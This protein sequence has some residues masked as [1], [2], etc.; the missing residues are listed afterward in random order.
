MTATTGPDA[1]PGPA[2]DSLL[3][4]PRLVAG[5]R[6]RRRL[7][8]SVA[9]VGMLAGALIGLFP[10]HTAVARVLIVHETELGDGGSLMET[11]VALFETNRIAAA[12]AERLGI[13]E[14]P[15]VFR[16]SFAGEGLTDNIMEITV[17]AGSDAEA[18][19]RAGA[20]AEVFLADHVRRTE[21]VASAESRALL[22]RREQAERDLDAVNDQIAELTERPAADPAAAGVQLDAL[23]GQR[24]ELADQIQEFGQ[25]AGDAGFGAPRVAA[26]TRIVDPPRVTTSGRLTSVV[27]NAAVGSVLGLGIG[28]ALAAVATIVRDRPVLRRDIADHLGASVIVQVDR[29]RRR[30][31]RFGRRSPDGAEH[32]R[33]AAALVR[34]VRDAPGGVSLL[35]IGCPEVAAAL[36]LDV[37]DG[38]GPDS[39]VLLLD[40]LPGDGVGAVVTERPDPDP[41][42]IVGAGDP[43]A[44]PREGDRQ[45]GV[46]SVSPGSACLD[47][48][49]LGR[50]TVLV[51]RA[52][53]AE[54]PWLHTVAR[55]LA[56]QEITV[57][58]VVLVHPD[59]RDRTDGTLWDALHTALRGRP[60]PA[61]PAPAPA[62][63]APSD[64]DRPVEPEASPQGAEATEQAE[65]SVAEQQAATAPEPGQQTVTLRRP[66]PVPRR[67]PTPFKRSGGA[68][69]A[70]PDAVDDGSPAE[71]ARLD[72]PVEV[73]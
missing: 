6:W 50:E 29:A 9:L 64:G 24:A 32:D 12:A 4:L 52:G 39:P 11:D 15:E 27:V 60:V 62:E 49:R 45:L 73:S 42:R 63:P 54:A 68:P 26:G 36:A 30:H 21:D 38:L 55:H 47:L 56:D 1:V 41:V 69:A 34:L 22:D 44:V 46:G 28:L 33:A 17:T 37:A 3:D 13:D 23:F 72:T 40:D 48:D 57:L 59:P 16:R 8:V 66:S 20:L 10:S 58:G 7:W 67:R 51:V 65:G 18:A 19:E 25:R 2:Q 70:P 5:V 31:G 14:R 61:A 71:D 53:H 35:E 43:S